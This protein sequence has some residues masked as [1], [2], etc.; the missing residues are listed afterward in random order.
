MAATFDAILRINAKA[1]GDADIRRLSSAMQGLEKAGGAVRS[2]LGGIAATVGVVGFAALGQSIARTGIESQQ[3]TVRIKALAGSYGEI[4]AVTD[5]A[6]R[7]AKQFALGNLEA[8]NAV[9]DLYG[10]LRPMGVSLKDVE[11]VF[12][13]VN[14]AARLMG[15]STE[16]VNGV[17]LQLS[18]A[19]GSGKLQGDELRSIMERMPAVGQAVAKVMGVTAGEIKQL[20]ADGKI[21]TEIMIQAAAELN[22]IQP[23]EPTPF[24]RFSAAQKDLQQ[25][26]GD[27]LLPTLTKVTVA[28]VSYAGKVQSFLDRNREQLGKFAQAILQTTGALVP[29]LGRVAAIVV[30]FKTLQAVIATTTAI[31]KAFALVSALTPQGMVMLLAAGTAGLIA[32]QRLKEALDGAT[33]GVRGM[34]QDTGNAANITQQLQQIWNSVGIEVDKANEKKKDSKTLAKEITDGE[35]LL[36]QR[37]KLNNMSLDAGIQSLNQRAAALQRSNE[38]T[39][40]IT[41]LDAARNTLGQVILQNKLA[42]AKTDAEKLAITRQ[43]AILEQEA[44]ELEYRATLKQIEYERQLLDIKRQSANVEYQKA[45]QA[46]RTAYWLK[47]QGKISDAKLQELAAN[48]N[49][50]ASAAVEAFNALKQFDQKAGVQRE[51]AGVNRDIAN[52]RSQG[53]V[54][55]LQASLQ[56]A[57]QTGQPLGQPRYW[58]NSPNGLIPQFATGGFVTRPTMAVIGEGGEPEYVVPQS[59]AMAFANNIVAGRTGEQAIRTA[60]ASQGIMASRVS[61]LDYR[62][63]MNIDYSR[64]VSA[65][66]YRRASS[67]DTSGSSSGRITSMGGGG[68]SFA[69]PTASATAPAAPA[70]PVNISI[71]TGPIM[72]F[73]GQKFVSYDDLERAMRATAD[74]VIGRLR[75]P[76]A[77][78]AL[79]R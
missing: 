40:Q 5:V 52:V 18:Q 70:P 76:A 73:N 79:G 35:K 49:A 53:Q 13:G 55:Q 61:A 57:V 29:I 45:E 19:L 12:F 63:A 39:G 37:I 21:T 44:A 34:A 23:P 6:T 65:L 77:R 71:Q 31:T 27:I 62:S 4:E 51:L 15:L 50:A 74:G 24:Q 41:G 67:P 8:R 22:K 11:T 64:R 60:R 68:V 7:A 36:G 3:A 54:Q 48:T 69:R 72:E 47:E 56:P 38:I 28:A 78:Q 42:L 66:D 43:I 59:K 9:T 32:F 58:I 26:L 14:K 2:A 33:E 1:T 75:T 10:R 46:L 20:G 25:T 17:M 16:D 30:A